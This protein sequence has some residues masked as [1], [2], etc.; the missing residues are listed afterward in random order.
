[1]AIYVNDRRIG[2]WLWDEPGPVEKTVKIPL[3]LLEESYND[4]MNL[5][6]LRLDLSEPGEDYDPNAYV[7]PFSPLR[8][9]LNFEKIEFR[10]RRRE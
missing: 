7:N 5:L 8:H 10:P 2:E 9:C 4:E 6:V 3:E 1:M